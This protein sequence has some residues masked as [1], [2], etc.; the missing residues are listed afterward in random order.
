MNNNFLDFIWYII[1]NSTL[2]FTRLYQDYLKFEIVLE[3]TT[4]ICTTI[5]KCEAQKRDY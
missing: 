5:I 1:Y 4:K 3:Q 2:R